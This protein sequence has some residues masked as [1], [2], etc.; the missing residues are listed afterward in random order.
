MLSPYDGPAVIVV[1]VFVIMD[2]KIRTMGKINIVDCVVNVSG[3][4][5]KICKIVF[6][7]RLV[8]LYIY[9]Y[10]SFIMYMYIYIYDYLQL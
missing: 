8:L 1:L 10:I 6:L 4:S 2:K 9:I 7:L 3:F 5:Y